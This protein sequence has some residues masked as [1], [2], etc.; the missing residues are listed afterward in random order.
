MVGFISRV[1]TSL[2]LK[3]NRTVDRRLKRSLDR[4]QFC[5]ISV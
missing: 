1:R 2:K 4:R 3:Q 5:F